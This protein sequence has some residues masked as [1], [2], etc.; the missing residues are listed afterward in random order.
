MKTTL[1]CESIGRAETSILSLACTT[2]KSAYCR[3]HAHTHWPCNWI[4]SLCL[5]TFEDTDHLFRNYDFTKKVWHQICNLKVFNQVGIRQCLLNISF[6]Y[7]FRLQ[8]NDLVP[9]FIGVLVLFGG[10]NRHLGNAWIGF[11]VCMDWLFC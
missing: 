10:Y 2:S 4:C 3:D 11:F 7:L 1:C 9:L 6:C 8:M 5:D